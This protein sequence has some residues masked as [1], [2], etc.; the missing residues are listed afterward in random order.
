MVLPCMERRMDAFIHHEILIDYRNK[1]SLKGIHWYFVTGNYEGGTFVE[2][3][4]VPA[5]NCF[6]HPCSQNTVLRDE[7]DFNDFFWLQSH[8]EEDKVCCA[9]LTSA[10]INQSLVRIIRNIQNDDTR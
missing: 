3:A 6:R 5:C 10:S 7:L 1:L 8:R 9:A 2:R 4:G